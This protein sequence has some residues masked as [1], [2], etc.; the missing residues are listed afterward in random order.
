MHGQ[1]ALINGRAGEATQAFSSVREAGNGA[2]IGRPS[3]DRY[4]VE[5]QG[6]GALAGSTQVA[7]SLERSL[8]LVLQV[9]DAR[10][11]GPMFPAFT[12]KADTK[13]SVNWEIYMMDS[14][15]IRAHQH[16]AGLKKGP[17]QRGARLQPA[18]VLRQGALKNPWERKADHP[19][20]DIRTPA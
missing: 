18:R 5:P 20:A 13:E 12:A 6:R 16:A 9:V 14:T 10:H 15:I 19:C 1:A 3:Q 11:L 8:Q 17:A 4:L 2:S 7:R